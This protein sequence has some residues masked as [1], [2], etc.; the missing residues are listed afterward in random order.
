MCPKIILQVVGRLSFRNPVGV[1]LEFILVSR[2]ERVE[3]AWHLLTRTPLTIRM[4]LHR[5]EW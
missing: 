5:L 4:R 1:S 2:D 3:H